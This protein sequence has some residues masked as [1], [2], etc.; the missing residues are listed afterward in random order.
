MRDLNSFAATGRISRDP[1]VRFTSD[2]K[3]V[4]SVSMAISRDDKTLWMRVSV[5]GK[6]AEAVGNYLHKGSKI[7]VT[8]YLKENKFTDKDGNKRSTIEVIAN[9]VVFLD[10]KKNTQESS[11]EDIPF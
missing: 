6:T 5:F 4:C 11:G 10:P 2:G 9:Q 7:A 1:E 3:A 8:G